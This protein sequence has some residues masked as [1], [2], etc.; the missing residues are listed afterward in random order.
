[1]VIKVTERK[2]KMAFRYDDDYLVMDGEGIL[3]KKTRNIPK[4][5]LVEGIVVNKIKLGEKIGTE[6]RDKTNKA[7]EL[8]SAMDKGDLYFV[9]LDMNDTKKVKAYI[10]DNM[11]VR[12]DYNTLM[13]NLKNGHLHLVVENLIN[14]GIKRG[15]ITFDED[16]S[17]SF[18][19]II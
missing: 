2:E 7:I 6:D 16:G 8:I 19:P 14:D 13:E 11:I 18:M 3:L 5:T 17:A 1:M 15:T 10:Y 12:A 4:T 9:K